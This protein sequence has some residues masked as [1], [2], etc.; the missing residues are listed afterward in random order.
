M[1]NV[2][3]EKWKI[4]GKLFWSFFWRGFFFVSAIIGF[5]EG[6]TNYVYLQSHPL[7]IA[8]M[9]I[10]ILIT[11]SLL[12]VIQKLISNEI[13]SKSTL[14]LP[15]EIERFVQHLYNEKKY[16]NVVRFGSPI[17]RFLWLNG[18]NS[19]RIA[20]GK[21][22]EDAASKVGRIQEQISALID[23]IGWTYF[24]IGEDAMAKQNINNGIEKAEYEKLYYFAAKGERHLA[25]IESSV[26]SKDKIIDH[27]N[28]AQEYTQKITDQ[29]EKNEMEASLFLAKAEHFFEDKDYSEAESNAKS[30]KAVFAN[31]SDRIVKVF[32][33][34]GNIY[35]TQQN[36]QKAKDEFNQGYN[37]CKD[38]RKDEFAKCAVG[39]AKVEMKANNL[40]NAK[41]YLNEAKEIFEAG[42]KYKE[43]TEV[44]NL[45]QQINNAS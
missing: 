9:L 41:T 13:L 27:L 34:L 42:S 19:E 29:S 31:D 23:D 2:E 25:G 39:L 45:L 26:G 3:I 20:I 11:L 17:S 8:L 32:S 37:R 33:L 15:K 44:K 4:A 30:A 22:V 12:F 14:N 38:F 1:T 21:M 40:Q 28:K 10:V 35:F 5:T 36:Y 24:V 7:R 43:L 6:F 18:N 16:L